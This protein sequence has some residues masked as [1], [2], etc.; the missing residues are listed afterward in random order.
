ML[1]ITAA[2]AGLESQKSKWMKLVRF[3]SHLA[4]SSAINYLKI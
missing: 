1:E 2:A 3:E 4:V